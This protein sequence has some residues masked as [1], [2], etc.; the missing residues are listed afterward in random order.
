MIYFIKI[1]H[2]QHYLVL[3]L[4]GWILERKLI[5]LINFLKMHFAIYIYYLQ[6]INVLM[7][8]IIH[9]YLF[10]ILYKLSYLYFILTNSSFAQILQALPFI[11][12]FRLISFSVWRIYGYVSR[13]FEINLT[14]ISCSAAIVSMY[15]VLSSLNSQ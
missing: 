9:I 15:F 14:V 4:Y 8:I 2:Y 6:S 12:Q 10:F 1:K 3:G 13:S 7:H 11:I 5:C